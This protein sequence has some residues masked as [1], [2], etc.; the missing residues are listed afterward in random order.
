ML[1]AF[2]IVLAAIASS[3]SPLSWALA[4]EVQGQSCHLP[5]GEVPPIIKQEPA[6]QFQGNPPSIAGNFGP[7][8]G[9]SATVPISSA[10]FENML[11]S[12][13][14]LQFGYFYSFGDYVKSG[15][16]T[17]SYFVPIRLGPDDGLFAQAN[18]ASQNYW[19]TP[20]GYSQG[21]FDLSVG[22]GYRLSWGDSVFAG[23]NGFY[24]GCRLFGKWYSSGGIGAEL[25]G[26]VIG[27]DTIEMNCNYYFG[28]FNGFGE[29]VEAFR[30]GPGNFDFEAGYRHR[31]FSD[32]H[33][34]RLRAAGYKFDTQTNCYGWRAGADLLTWDGAC[35]MTYEAGH[36][37]YNGMYQTV[38]AAINVPFQ[39]ENLFAG[40]NPFATSH[41]SGYDAY[42][43]PGSVCSPTKAPCVKPAPI[44]LSSSNFSQLLSRQIRRNYISYAVPDPPSEPDTPMAWLAQGYAVVVFSLN[45]KYTAADLAKQP[46]EIRV[47]VTVSSRGWVDIGGLQLHVKDTD[48]VW[49]LPLPDWTISMG[50]AYEYSLSPAQIKSLWEALSAASD[51]S[52]A[53]VRFN[54]IN[55]ANLENLRILLTIR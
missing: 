40:R 5:H 38:G 39:M 33:A 7:N 8:V 18:I 51:R 28:L 36:D 9:P 23:V 11:P 35:Q 31:L 25:V 48:T 12:I 50:N 32:D 20:M 55:G 13:P 15:V 27:A 16:F 30:K 17:G 45:P 49:F 54:Q 14:N 22:G 37:R 53:E 19:K 43:H 6:G 41:A 29:V 34:L 52:I 10:L 1:R 26:A 42:S 47:N 46:N 24:D 3:L 21:R 44:Y 2:C 4:Q